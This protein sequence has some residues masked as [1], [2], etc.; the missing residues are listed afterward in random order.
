MPR[1]KGSPVSPRRL[2]AL[3]VTLLVAVPAYFYVWPTFL[4]GQATYVVVSGTS[5]Q[6]LYRTGDLVVLRERERYARGQIIAYHAAGGVVIHRIVGGNSTDGF[7]TRGDNRTTDDP[8]RPKSQNVLGSPWLHMP[9][10]GGWVVAARNHVPPGSA[11]GGVAGLLVF[12]MFAPAMTSTRRRRRRRRWGPR[13]SQLSANS[14]PGPDS[15]PAS[16]KGAFNMSTSR[17]LRVLYSDRPSSLPPPAAVAGLVA[18]GLVALAALPL[19]IT[20]FHRAPAT[21]Q[22]ADHGSYT[23]SVSFSYTAHAAGSSVVYPTGQ[24]GPVT[25]SSPRASAPPAA[26]RPPTNPFGASSEVPATHPGIKPPLPLYTHLIRSLDLNVHYNLASAQT[27][28]RVGGSYRADLR[29]TTPD[30]WSTTLP[31]V[32]STSFQGTS[33]DFSTHIDFTKVSAV[34]DKLRQSTN[35]STSSYALDVVP[36]FSLRGRIGETALRDRYK[37]AFSLQVDE[38]LIQPDGNLS[39]DQQHRVGTTASRT[40]G[41]GL[42]GLTVPAPVGQMLGILLLL[43]GLCAAA[44]FAAVVFAGWRGGEMAQIFARYRSLLVAADADRALADRV[45]SLPSFA[46]LARV[47]RREGRTI[48]HLPV[49]DGAHRFF[50]PDGDLSYE[51]VVSPPARTKRTND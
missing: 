47:A 22:F 7:I 2:A 44:A 19:V 24:V 10:V 41:I 30:G 25:S 49:G 37:P 20:A 5:M 13:P 29:L 35:A 51:Y 40:K 42:L 33:A 27:P 48:L 45:I 8:W 4:L 14:R 36:G 1:A 15:N 34:L 16:S 17:R 21:R 38:Q 23:N 32:G 11:I 46:E 39:R 26:T 50:I 43:V 6:P 12:S 18:G 31:L 3:A 9:W 28:S